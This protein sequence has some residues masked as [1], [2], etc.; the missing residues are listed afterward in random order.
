MLHV[1]RI[2]E[3]ERTK[4]RREESERLLEK[5]FK[6]KVLNMFSHFKIKETSTTVDPSI[7][8]FKNNERVV[9]QLEY[10]SAIGSLMYAIQ[11][12]RLDIAFAVSKLDRFTSYQSTE[13]WKA[14]G[15]VFSYLK[16]T[17]SLD[18]QY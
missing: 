3:K 7:R 8:L 5:L 13:H 17:K 1:F 11:C 4:R 12:I 18:L 14:I 15:R 6:Y 16:K 10:A 2:D 9:A